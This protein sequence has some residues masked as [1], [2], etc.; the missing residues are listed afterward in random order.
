MRPYEERQLAGFQ[1]LLLLRKPSLVCL[2][3]LCLGHICLGTPIALS[4]QSSTGVQN[5]ITLRIRPTSD[6]QRSLLVFRELA[7]IGLPEQISLKANDQLET[8]IRKKCGSVSPEYISIVA[9]LNQNINPLSIQDRQLSLP[10]C[11]YWEFHAQV[12]VPKDE[13]TWNHFLIANVGVSGEKTQNA[14]LKLNPS[15]NDA[16]SNIPS[17]QLLTLPYITAEFVVTLKPEYQ[18]NPSVAILKLQRDLG[19]LLIRVPLVAARVDLV[20]SAGTTAIEPKVDSCSAEGVSSWPFDR[21][22]LFTVLK[23]QLSR[24]Q[25]DDSYPKAAVIVVA[26]TGIDRPDL[27]LF[28]VHQN[29]DEA[30]GFSDDTYGA[31]MQTMGGFPALDHQNPDYQHGTE[32]AGLVIGGIAEDDLGDYV[33]KKLNFPSQ[34]SLIK[35]RALN[36]ASR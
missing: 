22:E 2:I 35:S 16:Y 8:L 32:V 29:R 30:D 5:R 12:R 11:P 31:T 23:S 18:A 1:P 26:D 15:I 17:G 24:I 21:N 3:G 36:R 7:D 19:P 34:T 20:D 4:Q 33:R 14:V 27:H 6:S 28:P 13:V 10:P 25:L 9:Q